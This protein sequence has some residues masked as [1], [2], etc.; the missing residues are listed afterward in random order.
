MNAQDLAQIRNSITPLL[1]DEKS[2]INWLDNNK[3]RNYTLLPSLTYGFVVNVVGHVNFSPTIHQARLTHLKVK[4][5]VVAGSFDMSHNS[6]TTLLGAPD[7]AQNFCC[8]KNFL[9]S[10]E[11][12]PKI[13]NGDYDC[14]ANQLTSLIGAPLSVKEFDCSNNELENLEGVPEQVYGLDCNFNKIISLA[15]FPKQIKS[16][17]VVHNPLF[18]DDKILPEINKFQDFF[19]LHQKH[20][21]EFNAK[22]ENAQL[23]S[24]LP[25]SNTTPQIGKI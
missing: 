1:R 24:L 8:S 22:K 20:Q 10:L 18:D 17:R 11:G 14:S 19:T 3:V 6:F 7:E 12:G 21:L 25:P 2:I 9:T 4:F 23:H 5:G 16:F 13:V 15:F